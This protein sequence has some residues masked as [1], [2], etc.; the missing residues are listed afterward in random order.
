MKYKMAHLLR[1]ALQCV[2]SVLF[3]LLL[4]KLSYP[5]GAEG[6]IYRWLARLDPW[7]LFSQ[8]RWH[9]AVPS[10]GWLPL[11]MLVVTLFAG[12]VF[13][14]WLCPFGALLE[15][16]DKASRAIFKKRSVTC[17]KVLTALQPVRYYWLIVLAVVFIRI[18]LG[19]ILNSFC[20][21]QP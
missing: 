8:L 12:R 10:W 19:L 5:L 17:A 16:A 15:L 7:L 1:F 14:G 2:S 4:A 13:C 9:Y 6:P 21:I 11:L 18:K 20:I 3:V